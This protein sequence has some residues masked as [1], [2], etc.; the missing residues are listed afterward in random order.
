MTST[1]AGPAGDDLDAIERFEGYLKVDPDNTLLRTELGDLYHRAGRFDDAKKTYQAALDHDAGNPILRGRL[2]AVAISEQRFSEAEAILREL[3]ENEKDGENGVLDHNLGVSL[4]Y[5]KRWDEALE[6]FERA[7]ASGATGLESQAYLTR[8]LHQKADFSRAIEECKAWLAQANSDDVEGYLSL[9]EG[10]AGQDPVAAQ[11]RA[12]KVLARSPDNVD[13]AV[14]V[15]TEML[16][17]QKLAKS[18]E[19]F[20]RLT[21]RAPN[22]PRAWFGLGLAALMDLRHDDA[23]RYFR[24]TLELIP[25]HAGTLVTL[26]WV[27]ITQQDP[28][29]AEGIFRE[30]VA[31]DRTLAEAHGGLASALVAEFR[32]DEAMQTIRRARG[33]D[34]RCFGAAYATSL[35]WEL[36]GKHEQ[37]TKLFTKYL[38]VRPREDSMTA[39]EAVQIGLARHV[40]P[41]PNLGPPQPLVRK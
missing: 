19:M 33:L 20:T 11:A 3:R 31:S 29:T 38:E 40:R 9:L 7:R 5:Q 16:E 34:K 37:A 41:E 14:V 26:G 21:K 8:T 35:M 25:G 32:F 13:A 12:Q 22:N 39:M 27:Y 36:K 17:K 10:D 28:F 18:K 2:A 24:K 30:A 1:Q 6:C 23:I 15:G 4:V